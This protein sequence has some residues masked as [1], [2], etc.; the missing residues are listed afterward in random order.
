MKKMNFSKNFQKNFTAGFT[1][2]ELLVVVAIIG[3]LA[4]VVVAALTSARNKGGDAGVKA[5]LKNAVTQGEIFYGTNT[6]VPNSYTNF[7]STTSPQG[8][9]VTIYPLMTAAAKANGFSSYDVNNASSSTADAT[10][11]NSSTAWAAEVP[12]KSVSGMW[13]VDSTGVSRQNATS[14]GATT[15]C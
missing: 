6:A 14:I 3:L 8:G 12:L 15:N 4:A 2:L 11:N 7:C 13:C 9:A 5:N 1:L 10:C